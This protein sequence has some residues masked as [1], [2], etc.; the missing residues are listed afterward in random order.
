MNTK[1][2]AVSFGMTANKVQREIANANLG[3]ISE[4]PKHFDKKN[5]PLA[6]LKDTLNAEAENAAQQGQKDTQEGRFQEFLKRGWFDDLD[7]NITR[8][9]FRFNIM[10]VD[11]V[12]SGEIVA[13][14]GKPGAGKSTTL[15]ILIG[16]LLGKTEFAG[17]RCLTPCKRVLWIDTEKGA[18]SC[19]MKMQN[20]RRVARIESS[21]PL[22]EI[23]VYFVMMRQ[24]ATP[25]RLYFI[26]R[27]SQMSCFDAI[28]I[29]GIFDL[30]EDPNEGYSEATDLLRELAD[31]GASVFAMLHTNKAS[32]DSNMRYALGSELQRLCT[33]RFTITYNEQSKTHLITHDKSNDSSLAPEASFRFE[34]DGSVVDATSPK[35]DVKKILQ[36]VFSDGRS[37]DFNKLRTDFVAK[38]GV[39]PNE[40]FNFV[41]QAQ[42]DNWLITEIDGKINLNKE[43]FRG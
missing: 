5:D 29:D 4:S 22:T 11:C 2:S 8:P 42:K 33:T 25:D 28:V 36:Y 24:V 14:A 32:G 41:Q 12:P 20:F 39:K 13:I 19:K 17:I 40:A 35:I 10:G 15:A 16:I 1:E 9:N 26:R 37:R 21:K 18:Y 30:V 6:L 3:I 31:T 27:L 34:D 43:Y 7:E 38:S 23:G